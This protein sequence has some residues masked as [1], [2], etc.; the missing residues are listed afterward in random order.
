MT[1][2]AISTWIVEHA[3]TDEAIGLLAD[4]GF[5]AAEL[6]GGLAPLLADW[7]NDPEG[8]TQKLAAAGIA[9]R[10][11]HCPRPGRFLD[12]ENQAD[13]LASVAANVQYFEWM[14]ASGVPEI[15]IH[16]TS[17]V[18]TSTPEARAVV[19]ARIEESLKAL[20]DRAG[21]AG[22][23]MA[24]ENLGRDGR[25]GS[26]MAMLLDMIDGLGDHV[27]LCHDMG[28][29]VQADLDIVDEVRT[30]L[31]AGK[32]FSLH[33]HDVDA[34]K[35]DHYIPG[36]GQVDLEGFVAELDAA[37]FAGLRTLEIK[38]VEGDPAPRLRLVAAVRDR[39]T[40]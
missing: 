6:S 24:V 20:A 35:V 19:V 5:Q 25:P 9:V 32:L 3:P 27:G 31:R 39:W 13:R 11:V 4:A 23:R 28:H 21:Q 37:G 33:I 26:T 30:A 29:S 10:S 1:Q 12:V 15:V 36:E 40:A 22:V 7:E 34:S 38:P 17:G 18:D 14:A 2:Y 8:T 16:P